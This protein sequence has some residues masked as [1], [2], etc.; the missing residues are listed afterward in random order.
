[1][2]S[3]AATI[4]DIS[5]L[6]DCNAAKRSC[7]KQLKRAGYKKPYPATNLFNCVGNWATNP[8]N[9]P[10]KCCAQYVCHTD[11]AFCGTIPTSA[12]SPKPPTCTNLSTDCNAER[13]R[14]RQH[15]AAA[16]LPFT[17]TTLAECIMVA[18]AADNNVSPCCSDFVCA[19]GNV[20]KGDNYTYP[21]TM[22]SGPIPTNP[23]TPMPSTPPTPAP[24]YWTYN[25]FNTNFCNT[26]TNKKSCQA[27]L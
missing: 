22:G 19:N 18:V 12:P 21:P 5:D 11:A 8:A 13:R 6:S 20:C 1:M 23:P 10:T 16:N 26:F 25:D 9:N 24:T 17:P 7:E 15:F 14:C 4:G 2:G 27:N 3:C